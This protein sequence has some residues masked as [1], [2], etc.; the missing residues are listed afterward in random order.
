MANRIYKVVY[1]NE[2][3]PGTFFHD[4]QYESNKPLTNKKISKMANADNLRQV[5]IIWQDSK[6]WKEISRRANAG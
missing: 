3:D 1:T 2:G 5:E 4:F 6:W